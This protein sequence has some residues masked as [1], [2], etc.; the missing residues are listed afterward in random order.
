[1]LVVGATGMLGHKVSQVLAADPEL[2]VHCAVRDVPAEAFRPPAARYHAGVH[3]AEG[4]AAVSALRNCVEEVQP[5]V[6]I[7]AVGVIKQSR[8]HI[9]Q[10][11]STFFLNGTL[12]HLLALLATPQA[13]VVHVSTDCVFTGDR[14]DYT[15]SDRPDA[16]D[17]YGRSKA[18]GEL[19]Y[20]RHLTLRTSIIGP[21]L[22]GH[23][24]LFG[25]LLRQP[26]G[27]TLRGWS[28]AIFSGVPTVTLARTIR[29]L[30]LSGNQLTGVYH[31][32]SEPIDKLTLLTRL[33][34][35]LSLGHTIHED[36]SVV[37]DRSLDDRRFRAATGTATPAW[38]HL[39]PELIDDM[40]AWPYQREYAS[41]SAAAPRV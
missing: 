32:A 1:V 19:D 4:A 22:R 41:L 15:E 16:Q 29:D 25:W 24:G 26:R 18:C 21:E 6:V 39:I 2:E 20:G 12:P 34:D 14:G 3:L 5:D 36:S 13:Y 9:E 37:I 33:N 23:Y 17:V 38:D 11:T 40:M 30:L 27:S 35:A 28:R 7:N 8:D 10:V 31:I